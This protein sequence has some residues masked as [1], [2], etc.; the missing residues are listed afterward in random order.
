VT[1]STPAAPCSAKASGACD[2]VLSAPAELP[3]LAGLE[4]HIG[5]LYS[6]TGSNTG[7]A[8]AAPQRLLARQRALCCHF[9]ADRPR[10]GW[11]PYD[12][13]LPRLLRLHAKGGI[14]FVAAKRAAIG[15][16]RARTSS[17]NLFVIVL[18]IAKPS[19]NLDPPR[20][21]R[22]Q[23]RSPRRP[24]LHV[25]NLMTVADKSEPVGLAHRLNRPEVRLMSSR[26]L[27]TCVGSSNKLRFRGR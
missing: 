6:Y 16:V 22:R 15:S 5:R 24:L 7:S 11:R 20:H 2:R 23:A 1:F 9:P 14:T 4:R 12:D 18:V 25:G 27:Q 21:P 10:R 17:E 8:P 19:E 3:P 26:L 13:R